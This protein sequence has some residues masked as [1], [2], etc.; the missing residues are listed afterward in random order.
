MKILYLCHNHFD[1]CYSVAGILSKQEMIF[2]CLN[3]FII[4]DYFFLLREVLFKKAYILISKNEEQLNYL[5]YP[6]LFFCLI[7]Y[8]LNSLWQC[9]SYKLLIIQKT[10]S[11]LICIFHYLIYLC[12]SNNSCIFQRC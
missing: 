1:N 2:E 8:I 7:N 12:C 10:V 9:K 5:N 6:I 3:C 11:I 4:K